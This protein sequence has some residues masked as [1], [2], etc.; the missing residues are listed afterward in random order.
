MAELTA[1]GLVIRRYPE[2]RELITKAINQNSNAELIF[3]EDI[4]LGQIVS[5][6]ATQQ[7]QTEEVLQAIYSA[8]DRD[9]AEGTALDSLLSLVGLERLKASKSSTDFMLFKTDNDVTISAGYI[10]EN[11]STRERFFTTISKLLSVASCYSAEYSVGSLPAT[12]PITITVDTIDYTYTTTAAPTALEIVNGLMG[13]INADTVAT[14]TATVNTEVA[15]NETLSVTSDS[16]TAEI[17]VSAI[18]T[19]EP[20]S[21]SSFTSI[22]A[23]FAGPIKAPIGTITDPVTPQTVISVT[24]TKELGI[25]R[26]REEDGEARIRAS[27]SLAVSGSSTYAAVLGA[28]LNLAEVNTVLIEENETNTTNALGLPPHSFEVIV[29]APDSVEVNQLIA[30]TIWDEKPLGIQTHGNTTVIYK[31]TTNTDRTLKFSRPAQVITAVRITYTLYAEE[32]PTTGIETA[33]RSAV[34]T[35]G[36]SL[37]S[38]TDIIPKRFYED[39]YKNTTG[40]EDVTVEMQRIT[41]SGDT[42]VLGNWSEARIPVLPSETSS[43]ATA[44]ITFV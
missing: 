7:T 11:P 32:T 13:V 25:G 36:N 17:A 22:E 9:K 20:L 29:S 44:D 27:K 21:V 42:P 43:F 3:D 2:I 40:I 41:T 10:V 31:D 34:I 33:I 23:E 15:G 30:K 8:L 12:T 5:I 16:D 37:T 26:K 14:W 18:D 35:Y 4:I 28:I 38:G 19:I 39:I 1:A 6:I 24:N